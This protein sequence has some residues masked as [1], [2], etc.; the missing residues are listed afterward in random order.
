MNIAIFL[1]KLSLFCQKNNMFINYYELI[2]IY[3]HKK[4]T[5][6]MF[7]LISLVKKWLN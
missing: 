3:S 7:K 1:I 5:M 6:V 4:V 2:I